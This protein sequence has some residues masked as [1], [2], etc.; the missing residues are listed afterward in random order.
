MKKFLLLLIFLYVTN[1][2][3]GQIV[4]DG[5]YFIYTFDQVEY[6]K[7]NA[8]P[9]LVLLN[10][11]IYSSCSF[12]YNIGNC[13]FRFNTNTRNFHLRFYN[14]IYEN[15]VEYP[16]PVQSISDFELTYI[17]NIQYLELGEMYE[18]SLDDGSSYP[19]LPSNAICHSSSN[20]AIGYFGVGISPPRPDLIVKADNNS[21]NTTIEGTTVDLKPTVND[22][23]IVFPRDDLKYGYDIQY[24]TTGIDG[25]WQNIADPHNFQIPNYASLTG[26]STGYGKKLYLRSTIFKREQSSLIYSP[27]VKY[28]PY[29]FTQSVEVRPL[30]NANVA[31]VDQL[32]CKDDSAQVT[33][34]IGEIEPNRKID[35][36]ITC[37]NETTVK[38]KFLDGEDNQ[39]YN[40]FFPK[41]VYS[42]KFVYGTA[43][44]NSIP[45]SETSTESFEIKLKSHNTLSLSADIVEPIKCNGGIAKVKLSYTGGSGVDVQYSNG[46]TYQTSN[47]FYCQVGIKTFSVRDCNGSISTTTINISE[48]TKLSLD[49]TTHT[50]V[51]CF[52]KYTGSITPIA[53]G[54]VTP[55]TYSIPSGSF[56]N[57]AAGEYT[58]KVVDSN[59]CEL[60]KKITISQPS[61]A[62]T[63]SKS[64]TN[65]LCYGLSTGSIT[66]TGSGGTPPYE[67]KLDTGTYQ[68]SGTF[69][70]LTVGSYTVTV[71]DVNQCT[72]NVP[73]VITQPEF[74]LG[75]SV[76]SQINVSCFG[77]DNG[78]VTVVGTGGALEYEY[79]LNGG[80][81]QSSGKFDDLS[82]GSYTVTVRDANLCTVNVPVIITQ[83]NFPLSG[84]IIS[85]TNV[86]CFGQN[87]GSVSVAGA[88][89][90]APYSY[91][92][93]GGN[94]Q[95]QSTFALSAGSH[96]VTVRDANSCTYDLNVNISEPSELL[97]SSVN[98]NE[99]KCFGNKGSTDLTITGG[100]PPYSYS[101]DN[102]I[103]FS[104]PSAEI[105]YTF[106]NLT[107][108]NY[109]I[110]VKDAKGCSIT[111][112][113]T[114]TLSEPTEFKVTQSFN[115][116]S[117]YGLANGSITLTPSG[118]TSPYAFTK[119]GWA[120]TS[121]TTF[122]PYTYPNL[123][124]GNYNVVAKD[125]N[126]CV[127]TLPTI[128]I[129]E[130]SQ[131]E[132]INISKVNNR[133]FSGKDGVI[134]IN[135]LGG[136]PD[137]SYSLDNGAT[138]SGISTFNGLIAKK[139]YARVR[140]SKGCTTGPTEVEIT[141]PA[142]PFVLSVLNHSNITCFGGS[143]GSAELK[144][145][146][147][148]ISPFMYSSD[149]T[150]WSESNIF[151]G[152]SASTS[153][154]YVRD[155]E[156]CIVEVDNPITQ[157]TQIVATVNTTNI[158]CKGGNSGK[159][160][161][162]VEGGT[163]SYTLALTVNGKPVET[164]TNV[165]KT[166]EFTGLLAGT[167]T[168]TVT[169]AS[170]CSVV[171][172]EIQ[173]LEPVNPLQISSI[174]PNQPSCFGYSNG[175][176]T[177]AANG[178]W[179]DN[180][181]FNLSGT[182]NNSG[183][184]SGVASGNY[185][186]SVTDNLGC[187]V[188]S[189][190]TLDQ[191]KEL[192][193]SAN[194][195]N[196]SCFGESNGEIKLNA[197][198]GTLSHTFE[199][200][201]ISGNTRN[202]LLAG[203]Y[204]IKVTDANGCVTSKTATVSQPELLKVNL[205]NWNNSE[206]DK[207]CTDTVM[208]TPQGG[209]APYIIKFG[210]NPTSDCPN[211]GY[212][213]HSL[214]N[215]TYPFTI[216]DSHGC[217]VNDIAS[218]SNLPP[219]TL[220]LVE[221]VPA[222]CS[223]S[224]DGSITVLASSQT[225][226]VSLVWKNGTTGNTLTNVAGG[227]Y[228]A[229]ATDQFGCTRT[230]TFSVSKPDSLIINEALLRN[231]TCYGGADGGVRVTINGGTFP[232]S[233][234]WSNGVLADSTGAV[235]SGEYTLT[236]NDDKGCEATKL[237]T[238]TDPPSMQPNLPDLITLC[239]N[240]TY[241]ADA[242]VPGKYFVWLSNNGFSA[243]TAK[244]ELVLPG[245]YYL[246]VTDDNGCIGRD[247]LRIDSYAGV[248]DADF[249][250]T[251]KA[252]VGDTIV[253]I[254]MSWPI[255]QSIEWIYP[256]ASFSEI[257]RNEYSVL[258]IPQQEGTFNI[259]LVTF[260][261]PC[262]Q[263]LEKPIIIGPALPSNGTSKDNLPLFKEVVAYPNPNNGNFEL[264]IDMNRESNIMVE[265]FTMYGKRILLKEYRGLSTYR[266]PTTINQISGMY[267][268]RVTSG[269]ETRS[270][271]VVIQ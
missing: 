240:Q 205:S 108:G 129:A 99:I 264:F 48:P 196:V 197:T 265:V 171:V 126:G 1:S 20:N 159:I 178:G 65:V 42:Y 133:C 121:G 200:G 228:I 117:C 141:Q 246:M 261:G 130:P 176:I 5:K 31:G 100:T 243:T 186:I 119:D 222:S 84:N 189:I 35:F 19:S 211:D 231:P 12:P 260:A 216:T 92:L 27:T 30:P 215:G 194:V 46:G 252:F 233:Y 143:N 74:P 59:D 29:S 95:T 14:Y 77:G 128:T 135:A 255:P 147:G 188:D 201:G 202:N 83:P 52:G 17:F 37:G 33:I 102:G 251:D 180:Y 105:S 66:V 86:S 137:Y 25:S 190:F 15:P 241:M 43:G 225:G 245:E 209:T 158:A 270:L 113:S 173:I 212:L 111:Y 230:D 4:T 217:T 73:I 55:Y 21:F 24:S 169:D 56:S 213:L 18:I 172:N 9:E 168:L 124:K 3:V 93:N 242:G 163:G 78:S 71:R 149:G 234:Q 22:A 36:W 120:T 207:V 8:A 268:V 156:E 187:T 214:P 85:Q 175:Q 204:T 166:S 226:S 138:Y 101:K 61:S 16:Y 247:T 107:K 192:V 151:T 58:F 54:G 88:G 13:S 267:L 164:K 60:E 32:I 249:L 150:H 203:N 259:G 235:P 136:T 103:N 227:Q 125:A 193:L 82:A 219:P 94:F 11:S 89:G 221:A 165:S 182:D 238:V 41:G 239:T 70:G 157:P 254:E 67:Y 145:A 183:V 148:G 53:S 34:Q 98:V 262:T 184:F 160:S 179:D 229:V 167:Y 47:E 122:N 79:S 44:E 199:I 232:Y 210:D 115:N 51:S 97:F 206:G 28:S 248:I 250:M 45:L 146:Q 269:S 38:R 10:R 81:Y 236:V 224:A 185:T 40:I 75:G 57:L 68:T 155:A 154:F 142:D 170:S 49:N 90:T 223:Y 257:F 23:V 174:T 139:Y 116:I 263:Y 134:S 198:G 144:V 72:V 69:N 7:D 112:S 244:V 123:G 177:V 2:L 62:L 195:T 220:A 153:K 118:G 91:S 127:A 76:S 96:T 131:L 191:P 271:R 266:V 181:L 39:T 106:S 114:I 161:L 104:A 162:N 80:A 87:N 237:F 218:I 253:L 256:V 63:A 110:V 64:Q 208:V 132:I 50:D 26:E 140:D 258:L 109:K 152:L 6:I